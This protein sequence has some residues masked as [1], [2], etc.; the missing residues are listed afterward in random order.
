MTWD[1]LR[2]REMG[3]LGQMLGFV[4]TSLLILRTS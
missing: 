2:H 3:L 4:T 1:V